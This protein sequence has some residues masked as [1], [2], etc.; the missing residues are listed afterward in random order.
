MN[1]RKATK[2]Y[3]AWV[4]KHTTLVSADLKAKHERMTEALFPFFRATFYRW[5]QLWPK[6]CPE[7]AAA[8][9]V[10]GVGDLHVENFGTWRDI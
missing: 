8:P 2:R 6:L 4:G 3:E 9:E 1:I 5:A 7:L 10:L